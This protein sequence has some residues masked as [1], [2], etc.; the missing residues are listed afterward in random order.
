MSTMPPV[1]MSIFDAI[2][3]TPVIKLN[4]IVPDGSADVYIKLEFFNPTGCYKDRMALSMIEQAEKRGDLQPGMTVVE[5]TGGSTGSSLAFVCAQKGYNFEV[6]CSNAFSVEKLRSIT[7]LGAKLDIVHSPTG[8]VTADLMPSMMQRA[9]EVGDQE[10]YYYTNQFQNQDALIGYEGIGHE[11]VIQFPNGID[12]FCGAIGTAGMAMGVGRVFRSKM[13]ATKIVILEPASAPHITKGQTGPHSVEGIA[14]VS[15]PTHLDETLY[16]EARAIEEDKARAM[17]R[18][19][20][21]KEGLL[22]GTSTGINVVAALELAKEL[23]AGKTVV[24]VA[25]DT[26]LKYLNGNLF[27]E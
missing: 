7:A 25:V 26:G 11:L 27:Q 23:G 5:A 18:L 2:G 16:D 21:K 20:A 10:G 6:V 17:C 22:V 24:T 9:K 1:A 3:N 4:H 12:A 19:L 13:P 15:R 8:K 14:V